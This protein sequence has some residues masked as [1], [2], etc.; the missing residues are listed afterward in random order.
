MNHLSRI[1]GF[2]IVASSILVIATNSWA[3]AKAPAPAASEFYPLLGKW[4]GKGEL[5]DFGK[6]HPVSVKLTL[7]LSCKKVS[8]GWAVAC[9]M[10]A[11]NGAML[12]TESD[13]MGV[14]P[15]TGQA[16]WY[17]VTNQGET[18]DHLAKWIDAKTMKAHY[19]WT[20]GGAKMEENIVFNFKGKKSATWSS[21][22]TADGKR[23]GQFS[24]TISK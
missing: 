13:L 16:H 23:A 4:H 11:K 9:N 1:I 8:S 19:A 2:A 18:H 20:Q 21:V 12:M 24:G 5:V 22:V 15:V 7:S 6:D 14:D 3:E 10:M 17:A